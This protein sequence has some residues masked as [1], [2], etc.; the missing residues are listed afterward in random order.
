MTTD[1]HS[2]NPLVGL[3]HALEQDSALDAGVDLLATCGEAIA[4]R[5]V[6]RKLLTG[7]WL[8]HSLH[9]AATDLPLG[10]WMSASML[11]LLGP[12]GSEDAAKRLIGIGILG[13]VPTALSGIADW[14]S[15]SKQ[16]DRRV[17]VAHAAGNSAA[18]AAYTCSWVARSRGHHRLGA[19]LGLVGA[20]LSGAAGY[21]GGHLV[22]NGSFDG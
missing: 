14:R 22:E 16:G 10:A 15:L 17:G 18:L 21:L 2:A 9:P 7:A 6:L 1:A 20:A 8:G 12:E 13:A 3:T 19:T 4:D 5:P 11:D